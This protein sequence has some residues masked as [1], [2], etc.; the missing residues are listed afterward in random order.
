MLQDDTVVP[1]A[2][3]INAGTAGVQHFFS[4]LY[5]KPD[6]DQAVSEN[7]LFATYQQLFGYPFDYAVEPLLPPDLTQPA[8]QLPFEPGDVW[9]FTGGPHG[10]WADGAGWAALDF[11]PPG[12]AGLCRA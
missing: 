4:L 9:S 10:G 2:N 6:W 7:G 8:M 11:A 12:P 5:G 1:I 3:T